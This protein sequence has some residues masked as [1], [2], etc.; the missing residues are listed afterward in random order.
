M[1]VG[2][3]PYMR[4]LR[5]ETATEMAQRLGRN[6]EFSLLQSYID[7]SP[8]QNHL[9]ATP[10]AVS[11]S[12]R[13]VRLIAPFGDRK[14]FCPYVRLSHRLGGKWKNS[15][16]AHVECESIQQGCERNFL[17][18]KERVGDVFDPVQYLFDMC[19]EGNLEM[20]RFLIE[21]KK[22]DPLAR[23]SS[24]ESWSAKHSLKRNDESLLSTLG[25]W[26]RVQPK[27]VLENR[28][29]KNP[30]SPVRSSSAAN[31]LA[32]L[33]KKKK[34][35]QTFSPPR[36]NRSPLASSHRTTEDDSFAEFFTLDESNTPSTKCKKVPP[37]SVFSESPFDG[38]LPPSSERIA[39]F[40]QPK[41]LEFS[42]LSDLGSNEGY[43]P[44]SVAKTFKQ[45]QIVDYLKKTIQ[46]KSSSTY[47]TTGPEAALKAMSNLV[48]TPVNKP[49]LGTASLVARWTE[50]PVQFSLLR[51]QLMFRELI[52]WVMDY[53]H[54][55]PAR[56]HRLIGRAVIQLDY[57]NERR[58]EYT[59]TL[60]HPHGPVGEVEVFLKFE[61][62]PDENIHKIEE[63]YSNFEPLD[64][65]KAI[66]RLS[67]Q[68]KIGRAHSTLG[69][70][71]GHPVVI[72]PGMA[73][74]ALEAFETTEKDWY[75]E[76]VWIDPFKIGRLA[77]IE[78][79]AKKF[80]GSGVKEKSPK[81]PKMALRGTKVRQTSS[82]MGGTADILH[83]YMGTSIEEDELK[84][85][86]KNDKRRRWIEHMCLGPDGISD[87]PK[88]KVRPIH[89]IHGVDY[90][91]SAPMAR[92]P[93]YVFAHL[94]RA[95][96]EVGYDDNNLDA[97]P[98]DWRLPPSI[99]QTRDNYFGKLKHKIEGMVE[100]L[101]RPVVLLC[102]SMGN[103]VVQYFLAWLKDR[104]QQE[105]IDRNIYAFLALGAPFLGSPKAMR[106]VLFGDSMG[107]EMFLTQEEALHLARRS[108]S[109]PWLFPICE[110]VYP[111]AIFRFAVDRSTASIATCL[112]TYVPKTERFF[113]TFYRN[114]SLYLK[115]SSTSPLLPILAPPPVKRIWV[116]NGINR[117]TEV[118]YYLKHGSILAM[119]PTADRY[120]GKKIASVNPRGLIIQEGIS[121]ETA[122]TFQPSTKGNKSGD[123]TVPYCSLNY[124]ERGWDRF[125]HVYTIEVEDAE[126]RDMLCHEGVLHEVLSLICDQSEKEP[127]AKNQ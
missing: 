18:E 10:N 11:V 118:G 33:S 87:P 85:A 51:K 91:A 32:M 45:N 7:S 12:V 19:E 6:E 112:Q 27:I 37:Y 38:P 63:H 54:G 48:F 72:V 56:T 26:N 96:V 64:D 101:G 76:R 77:M 93:S 2:C 78:T 65:A 107:L 100:H 90:L 74:S 49:L 82:V 113:E 119:D 68:K 52:V 36:E 109:L 102:H 15:Y 104:H 106:T 125:M 121:F 92:A 116:V 105:W 28:G 60:L 84:E 86:D 43:T 89:G 97:A 42:Q 14:S 40:H 117:T 30:I 73:S 16:S 5:G 62:V 80:G 20:V 111:D 79:L 35:E 4:T 126:H 13:L 123:G 58:K 61:R 3:D 57:S 120:S 115:P 59:L 25:T 53:E 29:L 108:A 69:A 22:I 31:P 103:R 99:L 98:Y 75:C 44:L 94:I 83:G 122:E 34:V 47:K 23:R 50:P 66:K 39:E 8:V 127:K 67:G 17:R 81:S 95:L 71:P 110:E 46:L 88:I 41:N 21:S 114:D 1:S 9:A 70:G 55:V 124:A 24:R